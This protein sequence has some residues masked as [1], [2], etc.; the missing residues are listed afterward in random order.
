[1]EGGVRGG[2]SPDVDCERAYLQ[3]GNSPLFTYFTLLMKRIFTLKRQ[4]ETCIGGAAFRVLIRKSLSL[5]DVDGL[6]AARR[7]CRTLRES[8]E[9]DIETPMSRIHSKSQPR[10]DSPPWISRAG[11]GQLRFTPRD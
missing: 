6:L 1:M 8:L 5:Q 11:H 3:D 2:L 10:P 4:G 7:T 9:N